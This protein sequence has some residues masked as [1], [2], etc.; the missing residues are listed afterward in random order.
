MQLKKAYEIIKHMITET[1]NVKLIGPVHLPMHIKKITVNRSPHI[2]KKSREQFEI[3]TYTRVLTINTINTENSLISF[4][5]RT[6][7]IVF[8]GLDVKVVFTYGEL[9]A[10]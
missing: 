10:L 6:T 1:Q 3:R 4:I 2:D 9:L 8:F 5:D 7:K